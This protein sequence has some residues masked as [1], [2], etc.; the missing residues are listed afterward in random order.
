MTEGN[1]DGFFKI[2]N[3]GAIQLAKSLAQGRTSIY[4][5]V[6]T[7]TI[8]G[9]D[10]EEKTATI[11]IAINNDNASI[12]ISLTNSSIAIGVA[13]GDV[14][15]TLSATNID[16]NLSSTRVLKLKLVESHPVDWAD[17]NSNGV[18]DNFYTC[19]IIIQM[20]NLFIIF[21]LSVIFFIIMALYI[22]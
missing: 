19:L 13:I 6:V 3:E 2:N 14:V 22:N 5:L 8:T 18:S 9:D 11:T 16:G 21:I 4:T 1:D 10:A 12:A 20:Y 15:G 7:A 17:E